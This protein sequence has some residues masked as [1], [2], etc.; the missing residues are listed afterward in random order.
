MKPSNIFNLPRLFSTVTIIF[1]VI[2]LCSADG[3]SI[4]HFDLGSLLGHH[5]H[6]H[7]F[8]KSFS[9][10]APEIGLGIHKIPITIPLPTLILRKSKHVISKGISFPVHHHHHD[11]YHEY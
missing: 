2:V 9:I 4:G 1:A 6:H 8:S 7:G 5:D 11:D 10:H 3:I